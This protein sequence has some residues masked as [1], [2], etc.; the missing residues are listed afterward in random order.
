[1]WLQKISTNNKTKYYKSRTVIFI[2]AVVVLVT[3]F[4]IDPGLYNNKANAGVSHNLSGYAWSETVGW[5]SFNCTDSSSCSTTDYGVGVNKSSG[6]LF[7]YAWSSN[8]GWITFNQSELSG[9]PGSSSCTANLSGST[10]SGWARALAYADA[11]SGGWDGWISLNGSNYGV[12]FDT[13][14]NEFSGYAWGSDVVGWIDFNPQYSGVIK[15]DLVA[16]LSVSSN[17]ISSG[18]PVTLTWTSTIATSCSGTNFSTGGATSGNVVDYPT[19]TTSYTLTCINSFDSVNDV[20]QVQVLNTECADGTDNDFDGKIDYPNDLGCTSLS[21]NN[22]SSAE[23]VVMS[24]LSSPTLVQ[25]GNSAVIT[26]STSGVNS[27][28]VSGTNGDSWSGT[29]GSKNTSAISEQVIYTLTCLDVEN[30]ATNP[31][32]VTVSLVPSFQEF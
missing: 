8:I 31:Q 1:M 29:S 22:E 32:S 10:L 30:A 17:N 7:G 21:D 12:T 9:C 2:T 27:C 14:S 18:S 24:I 16:S 23:F 28:S 25:S 13:N 3:I 15:S 20:K 26:W 5:I 4:V 19:S 11:E 6:N